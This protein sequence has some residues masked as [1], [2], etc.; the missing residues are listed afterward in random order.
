MLR[1]ICWILW[2]KVLICLCRKLLYRRPSVCVCV[3]QFHFEYCW[4]YSCEIRWAQYK[5]QEKL[6]QFKKQKFTRVLDQLFLTSS[7]GFQKSEYFLE[8]FAIVGIKSFFC[9]FCLFFLGTGSSN[10]RCGKADIVPAPLAIFSFVLYSKVVEEIAWT[11]CLRLYGVHY[12][13]FPYSYPP[14]LFGGW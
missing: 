11:F 10:E 13:S 14:S 1:F 6:L 5:S 7:V 2:P 12:F 8:D 3:R 4:R 9:M